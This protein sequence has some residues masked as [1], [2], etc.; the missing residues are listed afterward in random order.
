[1]DLADF[2]GREAELAEILAA[3]ADG[4]GPRVVAI[5]GMGGSG[6]TTLAVRAAYRLAGDYPDGQLYLDLHGYTSDG[7][8]APVGSALD[9]LL[10]AMGVPREQIPDDPAGQEMLWRS[11]LATRRVLLLLDNVADGAVLRPL[12]PAAPGCVALVTSRARLVDLDGATW[13]SLGTMSERDSADL[14]RATLGADRVA[15]EPAAAHELAVLCGDLPLALRIAT[16][17]LRN[18]PRWTIRYLVDRLRDET[19]RLDE[20]SSGE[21]GV[22]PTLR[23]SYQALDERSRRALRLLSVHPGETID[24]HAAAAVLALDLREA[25]EVAEALL[26]V[27][28]LEQPAIG[29]YA[30]HD[31][32][33][34]FAA[35]LTAGPAGDEGALERLLEYQ[36]STS[37]AAC[38]LLFPGRARRPTGIRDTPARLPALPD[39]S[40]AAAWLAGEQPTLRATIAMAHRRGLD[41]HAA[42]LSHNVSLWLNACDM[43]HEFAETA[44]LAVAAARRTGDPRLLGTSLLNLGVACRKL[45]LAAEGMA[46]AG[47][48]LEVAARLG[49]RHTEAHSNS[50]L[51]RY[52]VRDGRYEEAFAHLAAA[53]EPHAVL[54]TSRAEAESL[55]ALSSLYHEQDRYEE[56]VE[57]A[58]RALDLGRQLTQHEIVLV[59]HN[60]LGGSDLGHGEFVEAEQWLAQGRELC[61][62][63]N[64]PARRR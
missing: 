2:T 40:A 44:R 8:P 11:T 37:D 14:I 45:G 18:R 63:S 29:L 21:R 52:Y 43:V 41:R 26:D 32:V 22:A 9:S 28:L 24:L 62:G 23:L 54:G 47:E 53:A 33:R 49:D 20:L 46:A 48:A 15:A 34:S 19:H 12:L 58:Q 51:G 57:A 7:Q 60:E 31:L 30:F 64:E 35:G 13:I 50:V 17:R 5:D 42:C 38:E 27:H 1:M 61:D 56:A 39:A 3:V 6:K 4:R 10:T 55:S 36:L 16:A 25:E 59:A